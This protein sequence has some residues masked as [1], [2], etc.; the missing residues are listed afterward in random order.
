MLI[1]TV[2]LVSYILVASQLYVTHPHLSGRRKKISI[3]A[4]KI[5]I[6]CLAPNKTSQTFIYNTDIHGVSG[7]PGIS[8]AALYIQRVWGLSAPT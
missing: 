3:S 5:I 7:V 1:Q 8:S 6:E 2:Y 4:S